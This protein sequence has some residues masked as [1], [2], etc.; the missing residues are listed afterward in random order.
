MSFL[1]KLVSA[2]IDPTGL[3]TGLTQGLIGVVGNIKAKKQY[4]QA[5]EAHKLAMGGRP[6][7]QISPEIKQRL[8]MEQAQYNAE[9]Q[10]IKQ[11]RA[12]QE[13]ALANYMG[14]AQRNASSGT[15]A[16][17]TAGEV[18]GNTMQGAARL[19]AQQFQNQLQK[20]QTLAQAQGAMAQQRGLKF[21]DALAANQEKQAFELGKMQAYRQDINNSN[22][23]IMAAIP[24]VMPGVIGGLSAL[25]GSKGGG[26][27]AGIPSLKDTYFKGGQTGFQQAMGKSGGTGLSQLGN[28]QYQFKLPNFGKNP[29]LKSVSLPPA[30]SVPYNPS[31]VANTQMFREEDQQPNI[32]QLN[33]QGRAE[34]FK[35]PWNLQKFY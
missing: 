6:S 3:A 2:G 13:Q 14:S 31:Y 17:A 26:V 34:I 19:G 20:G 12:A 9:D 25:L 22:K 35:T 23:N 33:V 32:N 28:Q 8:A 16:L 18:A 7:F 1:D 11:A 27:G 30:G 24:Q 4:N 10:S 15:Q 21:E 5:E 29:F